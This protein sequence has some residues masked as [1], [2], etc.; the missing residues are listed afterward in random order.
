MTASTLA[1]A[2]PVSVASP[3]RT[4]TFVTLA[5]STAARA[6]ASAEGSWSTATTRPA[7]PDRLGQDERGGARPAPHDGDVGTLDDAGRGPQVALTLAGALG[8]EPVSPQLDIAQLQC[9]VG[10]RR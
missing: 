6:E 9:V 1:A 3:S 5:A 10:H 2:R 4:S 7:W 8:H